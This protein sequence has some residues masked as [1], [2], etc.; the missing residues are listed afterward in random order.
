MAKIC[1]VKFD[2][3]GQNKED[4]NYPELQLY[5]SGTSFYFYFD[6]DE[7][8]KHFPKADFSRSDFSICDTRQKAI[9]LMRVI[10]EDQLAPKRIIGLSISLGQRA[11]N[12]YWKERPKGIEDKPLMWA[13]KIESDG[14][15]GR[16]Y[17]TQHQ[18]GLSLNRFLIYEISDRREDDVMVSVNDKWHT[19]SSKQYSTRPNEDR[20]LLID[21]TEEREK[22]LVDVCSKLDNLATSLLLFLA[23]G[24][25][26][27]ENDFGKFIDAHPL[28]ALESNF[29]KQTSDNQV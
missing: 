29:E 19:P 2:S 21:W 12:K 7:I 9:N 16:S 8:L 5:Y 3:F 25:A 28:P 20:S 4:G 24:I 22:Y 27:N 11:M 17:R 15:W 14:D 10:A 18:L 13:T 26:L 6:N 23:K 1:K